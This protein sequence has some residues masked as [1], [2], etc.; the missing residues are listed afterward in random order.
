MKGRE[1]RGRALWLLQ[2]VK[3]E[4]AVT[5]H[6]AEVVERVAQPAGDLRALDDRRLRVGRRCPWSGT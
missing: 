3:D 6:E 4:E 2:K 1:E 5:G